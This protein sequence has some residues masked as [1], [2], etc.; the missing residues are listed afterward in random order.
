MTATGSARSKRCSSLG[1]LGTATH[2]SAELFKSVA[3][4]DIVR[5]PYKERAR[6]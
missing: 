4:V 5:V 2:I 1:A 3:G 6:R